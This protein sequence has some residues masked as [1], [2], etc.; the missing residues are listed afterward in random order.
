MNDTLIRLLL[1]LIAAATVVSGLVQMVAPGFVLGV[2]GADATAPSQHL[3][4]TVGMFMLITGAMFFQ[5]LLS[6]SK[7]PAI[8]L[9]IGVQKLAAAALVG[10]GVYAGLFGALALGVAGFDLITGILA[11]LFLSRLSK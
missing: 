8:P 9:W 5:A 2:I 3:F 4:R 11:L 10:W 1:I 7:E 6:Q